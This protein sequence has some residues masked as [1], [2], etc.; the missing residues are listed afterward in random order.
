VPP[1]GLPLHPRPQRSRRSPDANHED[2]LHSAI[3]Y[4]TPKDK[5][6]GREREIFAARD[7][8]LEAARARRAA[9]RARQRDESQQPN[10]EDGNVGIEEKTATGPSL[11]AANSAAVAVPSGLAYAAAGLSSSD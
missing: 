8:K 5:L 6:E 3:G 10:D 7:R 1:L 11:A 9:D 4:V 2:R